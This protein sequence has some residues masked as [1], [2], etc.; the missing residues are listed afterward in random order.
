MGLSII[1][2]LRMYTYI[3]ARRLLGHNGLIDQRSYFLP[4]ISCLLSS[5]YCERNID[6]SMTSLTHPLASQSDCSWMDS[7][8]LCHAILRIADTSIECTHG[9]R[10]L[11]SYN[12]R[13]RYYWLAC[14]I[15]CETWLRDFKISY[16][17][18]YFSNKL[19]T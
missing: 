19:Q 3:Y 12:A 11:H 2:I 4:I 10:K 8:S 7:K 1:F 6:L 16:K 15:S 9:I 17:N 13:A 5:R 18:C 14:D